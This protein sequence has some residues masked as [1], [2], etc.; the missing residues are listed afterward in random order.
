MKLSSYSYNDLKNLKI[1]DIIYECFNG[2]NLRM[3]VSV[4]PYEKY[5]EDLNA[6]QLEWYCIDEDKN[7]Q[8]YFITEG[9]THYG[10]NIYSYPAYYN[11]G[12]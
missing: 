12:Q 11:S 2:T 3:K 5:S 10:P 9:L 1:N 8:R 6:N 7:E 4:L